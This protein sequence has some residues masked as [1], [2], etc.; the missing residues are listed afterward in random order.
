V[1]EGAQTSWQRHFLPPMNADKRILFSFSYP[2]SSAFIGGQ[3]WIRCFLTGPNGPAVDLPRQAIEGAVAGTAGTVTV[4][5]GIPTPAPGAGDRTRP[6]ITRS[7]PAQPVWR[8]HLRTVPRQPA[9]APVQPDAESPR[10]R[11]RAIKKIGD[12]SANTRAKS[13]HD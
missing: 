7:P 5:S 13:A 10:Y 9:Q 12:M 4:A 2:R 8:T 11:T 1:Q 3:Y 6:H